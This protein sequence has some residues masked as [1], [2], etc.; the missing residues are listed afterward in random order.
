MQAFSWDY[1]YVFPYAIFVAIVANASGFSGA[2]LFQPFFNFVLKLPIANSIAT[3]VAT[4]TIGMSSG[5]ARY[6]GM[7]KIDVAAVKTL[8]PATLLGVGLGLYLFVKVDRNILRLLV[9]LVVGGIAFYQFWRVGKGLFG[10]RES[11]DLGRLGKRRWVSIFAGL[12]SAC[13]GTGVAEMSQPLLEQQ[14]ELATKRAN[15]TAIFLE[16][17]ADW[18]ITIVNLKLGNIRPEILIFSASGVLI[19]GQIGAALSPYLP[20][21]ILKSIFA[22]AILFI[23]G[24]YVVTALQKLLGH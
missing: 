23:G 5:A 10:E 8:L 3:G 18:T 7:K 24:V 13:T 22:V 6:F 2:V 4:E 9:G 12:F 1:W 17:L 11:A 20:D 21:R 15:A 14:G 19:G 16:A